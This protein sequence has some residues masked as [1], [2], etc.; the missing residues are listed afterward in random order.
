MAV[1]RV[2]QYLYLTALQQQANLRTITYKLKARDITPKRQFCPQLTSE[3]R[4]HW[5]VIKT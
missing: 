1:M 4:E 2:S 3:I 5:A